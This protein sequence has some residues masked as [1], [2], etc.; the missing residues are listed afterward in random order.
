MVGKRARMY[1]RRR[2]SAAEQRFLH[3]YRGALDA[4]SRRMNR[5][6]RIRRARTPPLTTVGDDAVSS[7]ARQRFG[8]RASRQRD[9]TILQQL[10]FLD[11]SGERA[12]LV[13]DRG[14]NETRSAKVVRDLVSSLRVLVLSRSRAGTY[15]RVVT[16]R[17][18]AC[19]SLANDAML[20][21]F[22]TKSEKADRPL[23]AGHLHDVSTP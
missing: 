11:A 19:P 12:G 9:D 15:S 2:P 5:T 14:S 23:P 7:S 13:N 4:F 6:R 1:R 21:L 8:V 17:L 3:G 10:E 16:P 20:K 22:S 18:Q